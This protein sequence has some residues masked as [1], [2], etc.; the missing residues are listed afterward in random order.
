[1]KAIRRLRLKR[2]WTQKTLATL[3]GLNPAVVHY[4]EHDR[5]IP[6]VAT[7]TRLADAFGLTLDELIS[8]EP[9][10]ADRFRALATEKASA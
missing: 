4:A 8:Y 10:L 9:G 7:L 3:A 1:M 6:R 5:T 2:H